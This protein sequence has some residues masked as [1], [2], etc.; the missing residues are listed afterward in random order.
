MDV[1]GS[2]SF[3]LIKYK[4]YMTVGPKIDKTYSVI[5]SIDNNTVQFDW[6]SSYFVKPYATGDDLTKYC[7]KTTEE[8]Q[9]YSPQ[10]ITQKPITGTSKQGKSF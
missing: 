1:P 6:Q 7:S 3:G 9:G 5:A 4:S 10:Q 2:F 8:P